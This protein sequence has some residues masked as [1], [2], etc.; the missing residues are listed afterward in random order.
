ML[1][2][3]GYSA[4]G[5]VLTANHYALYKLL[6]IKYLYIK[7]TAFVV[8]QAPKTDYKSYPYQFFLYSI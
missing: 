6:I 2:L 5:G 1:N 4:F 7:L 3:Q 8:L